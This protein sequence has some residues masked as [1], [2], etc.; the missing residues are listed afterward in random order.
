MGDYVGNGGSASGL[1]DGPIVPIASFSGSYRTVAPD[2]IRNGSTNVLLV[3]EKYIDK[4]IDQSSS[5]CN[6]DQGWT[7][8][9]DNDT[10]G[11]GTG[12]NSTATAPLPDGTAS[13]CGFFFGG[14]HPTSIQCVLCDGSVRAVSYQVNATQ[15]MYFCS[16]N[17][18]EVVNTNTF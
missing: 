7:D 16:T 15:W 13:T 4:L 11:Y 10:I 6:D 5:D 12:G 2:T 14:I 18:G 9:F 17:N 1:Y 8:G 3:A